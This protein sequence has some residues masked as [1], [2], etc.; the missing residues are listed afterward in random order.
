MENQI[1]LK[2]KPII[3]HQLKLIGK[4]VTERLAELNIDNLVA[5]NDT[6]KSLKK[7]RSELNKEMSDYENQRK[8]LKLAI[9]NPYKEFEEIYKEEISDKF[10]GAIEK[11]KDKIMS[12][13]IKIKEEKEENIKAYFI[14]LCQSEEIDFILYP[15]L[16]IEI[17][18]STT[19]KVYKE[20]VNEFISKIKDDLELI[21]TQEFE[22]EIMAE[23]KKSLNASSAITIVQQRKE[24]DRLEAERIKRAEFNRRSI[25][26]NKIGMD[27]DE[28]TNTFQFNDNIYIGI[29][30]IKEFDKKTF[31]EKL[32]EFDEKIKAYKNHGQQTIPIEEKKAE[33]IKAPIEIKQEEKKPEL[34]IVTASFEVKGTLGQLKALGQYMKENNITYKN[35]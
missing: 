33:P 21:K 19:E 32:I 16:G 10:T 5:N 12:V 30:T 17:N 7:L 3:E 14:E 11:L 9:F 31:G 2:Q 26:L 28:Q 35:I 4:S 13:E 20:K 1:V 22:A 18:L 25:E 8:T 6:I 27:I 34:E 15:Q 23:F 29:E 24:A